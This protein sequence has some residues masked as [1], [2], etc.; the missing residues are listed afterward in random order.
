MAS[1]GIPRQIQIT[2]AT[3]A[4]LHDESACPEGK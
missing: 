3:R 4:S 2:A 1:Y